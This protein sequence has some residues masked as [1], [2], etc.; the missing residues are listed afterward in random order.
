MVTTIRSIGGGRVTPKELPVDE[1]CTVRDLIE[2]KTKELLARL[3]AE[4][5]AS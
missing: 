4:G 1:F 3:A 2:Q 5:E